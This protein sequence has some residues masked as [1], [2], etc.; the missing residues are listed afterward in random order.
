MTVERCIP[1]EG[2]KEYRDKGRRKKETKKGMNE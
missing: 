1:E 2:K